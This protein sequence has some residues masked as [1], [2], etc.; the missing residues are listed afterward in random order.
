[1]IEI[2]QYVL[3]ACVGAVP[4]V[5][6]AINTSRLTTYKLDELTKKVEKHNN[7]MERIAIL[8]RDVK[9]LWT[10]HDEMSHHMDDVAL[11]LD[12]KIEQNKQRIDENK[13]Q[14]SKLDK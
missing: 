6:V 5:I 3:A 10:K 2:I 14:I 11:K 1:M 8:E 12:T 4:A 7:F 9:T 13:I